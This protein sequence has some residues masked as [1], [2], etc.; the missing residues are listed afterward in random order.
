MAQ[1]D[2]GAQKPQVIFN[3]EHKAYKAYRDALF[4][5]NY[6]G[7]N[8]SN[9]VERITKPTKNDKGQTGAMLHL[10]ADLPTG[11]IL[12]DNQ[13]LGRQ[14]RLQSYWISVEIDQITNACVNTGRLDDQASVDNFR[15]ESK[16][17]LGRVDAQTIDEL[18]FLTLSG[19]SYG[20][21]TD[22]STRAIL[23]TQDDL[24]T[25][26]YAASVSAPTANRYFVW[27][28]TALLK[29][30]SNSTITSSYVP[31]YSMIVKTMAQARTQRL[32]PLRVGGREYY[33]FLIHP[34]TYA[35]LKLDT[36]FNQAVVHGM[37]RSSDNP[38]FTGA[39]ITIDG[40]V[41]ATHNY[42]FNT[43]GAAPGSKW[44]AGGA[45][46]G[47]RSLL[48]GAQALGFV[49][50]EMPVWGEQELD[51]G[52]QQSIAIQHM[53]G[54]IKPQFYSIYTKTTEDFGVMA[55]DHFISN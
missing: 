39:T 26:R 49:D 44:G 21:N 45:V 52:R 37:P 4:F 23:P 47:T 11:G 25:L 24:T 18:S 10:I 27:N 48:L 42:V 41:I 20:L 14:S 53:S 31:T 50:M 16:D 35:A 17:R 19:I 36:M 38:V 1:T 13:V 5:K 34:L 22:G 12:G 40:A 2:F 46:D 55:I 51:H 15:D 9:V 30:V 32:P 3:W 54:L 28:G 7:Q 6:Q 33:V 29:G 43:L 8:G